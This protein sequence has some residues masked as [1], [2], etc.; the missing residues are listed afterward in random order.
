MEQLEIHTHTQ[1]EFKALPHSTHKNEL[2]TGKDLKVSPETMSI[3]E[4]ISVNCH[5][6]GLVSSSLNITQK[7]KQQ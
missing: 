1:K 5:D 7:H 3:E 4:K 2:K 6:L